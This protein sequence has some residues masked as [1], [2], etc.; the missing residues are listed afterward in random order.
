M[1]GKIALEEHFAIPETLQDSAGFVPGDYWKELAGNFRTQSLIDSI[2]EIGGDRILF[3]TDWP[4]ENVDHAANWFDAAAISE[5]DRQKIG[6]TNSEQLFGLNLKQSLP[7][8]P[9]NPAEA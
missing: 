6:R 8:V 7:S 2:M 4:F 1:K 3:S 9:P 5:R